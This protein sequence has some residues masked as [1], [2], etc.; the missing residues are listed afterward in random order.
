MKK[1]IILN[2]DSYKL[3]HFLGYP[4]GTEY[5]YS[6]AE[7]RG[8]V[9][10]ATIFFGLQPFIAEYLRT[11]ITRDDIFEAK[12]FSAAHGLPFNEEG[13]SHILE[14][15]GGFLPLRIKAVPEGSLIP[16]RNILASVE[17]TDPAVP[18][19]TSYIETALLRVWYPTT[20]ATRIFHMKKRIK[21]FFDRTSMDGNMDFALLD[22]SSRGCSS[23]ETNELGGAAYLTCFKG[24]DSVPA[25]RF[26]NEHYFSAMSGFSVPATEHSIMCAYGQENEKASFERLLERMGNAGG[27][28]SVVSD[29]WDIYNA[30]NMWVEL[31]DKV[32]EAGVTLVVRPDSGDI[33]E[34]LHRVLKTLR[35]GFGATKNKKGFDVLNNVKVLWGD[36]INE[37]SCSV[38]FMV[39]EEL[40]ISADSVL[41]GSGGGLMQANID[42]D[43]C[44]F[45][46]KAS[47]VTINGVETPISKE[48][49]TDPGKNSK[50]GRQMLCLG[51]NGKYH[52][53]PLEPGTAELLVDIYGEDHLETVYE[54]GYEMR[55]HDIQAIRERIDSYL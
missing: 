46:F 36:G 6:Y 40:G 2:T 29:T 13:W 43:T 14:K 35:E 25:V 45:A 54:N 51:P 20:V 1:N 50:R 32:K 44:K 5:V 22:F 4:E 19:L 28:L 39:A 34:V 30:A 18:W 49:I 48:P 42:R 47:E 17:N 9:Y 23:L 33:Q 21:P 7:S 41:I 10:P 38:P 16:V 11:P 53:V 52:T 12:T 37:T 55:N 3:S 31:H 8:G 27:I 24:S 26:V 15:H